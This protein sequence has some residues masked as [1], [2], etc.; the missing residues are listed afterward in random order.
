MFVFNGSQISSPPPPSDSYRET[1]TLPPI[2]NKHSPS[3][4]SDDGEVQDDDDNH[5]A[6]MP[7]EFYANVDQF[8]SLNP[9]SLKMMIGKKDRSDRA[10]VEQLKN[11]RTQLRN[12]VNNSSSDKVKGRKKDASGNTRRKNG[13]PFDY[14]LLAE[15]MKFTDAIKLNNDE[16]IGE[17]DSNGN[18]LAG[19]SPPRQGNPVNALRRRKE[20]EQ[21]EARN[22]T[23]STDRAKSADRV[24]SSSKKSSKS[25]SVYESER[26]KKS[27]S[28][29]KR[30]PSSGNL[31]FDGG[32]SGS[33]NDRA[34]IDSLVQNFEQGLE[35][36]RLRAELAAS[37][38]RMRDST[39][40]IKSAASEFY[41]SPRKS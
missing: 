16:E 28:K 3:R 41:R 13:E 12:F 15:A 33:S 1:T 37:Q 9:P 4:H 36:S 29:T 8:L 35:L 6:T 32:N 25:T 2:P 38:Q 11:E 23:K 7:V 24:S 34:D 40:A 17:E 27:K 22:S 20:S 10:S 18:R 21:L 30:R 26:S 14:S 31:D 39:S 5:Q 19:G